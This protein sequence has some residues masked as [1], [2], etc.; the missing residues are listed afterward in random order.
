[1]KESEIRASLIARELLLIIP[2]NSRRQR[3]AC[4]VIPKEYM[5]MSLDN[6]SEVYLVPMVQSLSPIFNEVI[7]IS[8]QAMQLTP[9]DYYYSGMPLQDWAIDSFKC[10]SQPGYKCVKVCTYYRSSDDV[11]VINIMYDF[12]LPTK[13]KSAAEKLQAIKDIILE[14]ES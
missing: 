14:R 6:F 10:S 7:Q 13:R 12:F 9:T 2:T 5:G 1:M 11:I 4:T 8:D 3:V